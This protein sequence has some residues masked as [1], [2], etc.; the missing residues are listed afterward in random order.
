M[1]VLAAGFLVWTYLETDILNNPGLD[2]MLPAGLAVAALLAYGW[3]LR[4][5]KEGWTFISGGLVVLLATIM[6]FA[7]LYPRILISTLETAYNLT[8]YN[9]AAS[10]YSLQIFTIVGAILLPVVIL[11]QAWTY[12]IFKER[13]SPDS[14]QT[15]LHY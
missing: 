6:V 15:D 5:G 7:G 4:K 11:Y 9:S 3:F 12:W 14:S 10:P 2:G 13:I 8:I 1:V